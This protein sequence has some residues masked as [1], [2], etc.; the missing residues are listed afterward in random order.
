MTTDSCG[1]VFLLLVLLTWRIWMCWCQRDQDRL[2]VAAQIQRSLKP[3]TPNDCPTCCQ[4]AAPLATLPPSLSVP[5][6]RDRK[7]RRAAPKP[8]ATHGFA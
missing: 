5:A 6:W 1:L 2:A 8:I 3:R 7:S 4:Q